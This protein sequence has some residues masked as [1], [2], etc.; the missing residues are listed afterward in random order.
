M[1]N[2]TFHEAKKRRDDEFYTSYD[3]VAQEMW[4]HLYEKKFAGK[5]VIALSEGVGQSFDLVFRDAILC[6]MKKEWVENEDGDSEK[7]FRKFFDPDINAKSFTRVGFSRDP[8][9]KATATRYSFVQENTESGGKVRSETWELEGNGDFRSDEVM[10]LV[11]DADI[12]VGNPP[13]SRFREF[14]QM[15]TNEKKDFIIV[16]PFMSLTYREIFDRFY[17]GDIDLGHT[18]PQYFEHSDGTRRRVDCC[19]LCSEKMAP[20]DPIRQ[21][22]VEIPEEPSKYP[23]IGE[24]GVMLVRRLNYI[25]YG[26][27]GPMALPFKILKR[28]WRSRYE[29]MGVVK[30]NRFS[31][32][33]SMSLPVIGGKQLFT[34][35][36]LQRKK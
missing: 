12:V 5:H 29:L 22:M 2:S 8:N 20:Q 27:E 32:P 25:P 13:F 34:K 30:S 36:I 4:K 23:M 6:D 24:T 11:R 16:A 1:S 17:S 28:D 9:V 19:Y 14:F 21:E 7:L 10:K 33:L 15:L 35:V 18:F 31:G 26:Y 3:T